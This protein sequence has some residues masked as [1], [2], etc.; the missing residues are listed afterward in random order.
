[1]FRIARAL[2]ILITLNFNILIDY[3]A[4][5]C[6]ILSLTEIYDKKKIMLI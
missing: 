3:F 1:M 2:V 5:I 4:N 6:I